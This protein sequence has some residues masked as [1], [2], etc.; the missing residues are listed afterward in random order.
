MN[1]KSVFIN[2]QGAP[3][4]V[5]LRAS[6]SVPD[7]YFSKQKNTAT[8]TTTKEK[9]GPQAGGAYTAQDPPN[10]C[11]TSFEMMLIIHLCCFVCVR[12]FT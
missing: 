4:G 1:Y 7:T 9:N 8:T 6:Q 11:L 10:V 3:H 12:M 5:V 2:I